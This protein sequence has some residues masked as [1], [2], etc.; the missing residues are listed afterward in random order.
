MS[1]L[2]SPFS[3]ASSPTSS[4]SAVSTVSSLP[5]SLAHAS[6]SIGN[7]HNLPRNTYHTQYYAMAQASTTYPRVSAYAYASHY[8][9]MEQ[10]G[11]QFAFQPSTLFHHRQYPVSLKD[12][13]INSSTCTL[14]QPPLYFSILGDL[15]RLYEGNTID[16]DFTIRTGAHS[17]RAH[18]FV[19]M[20][21][22]RYFESL[23]RSGLQESI[24]NEMAIDDVA[25]EVMASNS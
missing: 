23:F 1:E 13:L 18:R 2:A 8:P 19:L 3:I 16:T 14:K 7:I 20:F 22:S 15:S 6:P 24:Q 11:Y 5:S 9:Q 4:F 25:P 17:H 10:A 21:R 12:N